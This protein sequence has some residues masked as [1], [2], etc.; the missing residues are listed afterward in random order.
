MTISTYQIRSVLRVYGNQLK[1]RRLLDGT[2][3]ESRQP[4]SEFVDIS[5]EAR[6]KQVLNQLS[7]KLVSELIPQRR[8]P[9]MFEPFGERYGEAAPERESGST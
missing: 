3:A 6:K 5:M 7:D 8:Q 2:G 9:E 4:F 1:R